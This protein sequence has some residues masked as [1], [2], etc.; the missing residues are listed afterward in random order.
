MSSRHEPINRVLI[1]RVAELDD[2]VVENLGDPAHERAQ[3][4][5]ELLA[6]MRFAKADDMVVRAAS[7][8][9]PIGSTGNA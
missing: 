3:E 6:R 7:T 1:L 8:M 5:V 4:R 9:A 2:D